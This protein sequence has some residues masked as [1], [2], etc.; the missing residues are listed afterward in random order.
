[1]LMKRENDHFEDIYRKSN[2][3]F[4][5]RVDRDKNANCRRPRLWSSR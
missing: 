1:M 4:R 2:R 5:D 3:M